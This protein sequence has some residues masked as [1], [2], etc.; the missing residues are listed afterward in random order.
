MFLNLRLSLIIRCPLRIYFLCLFLFKSDHKLSLGLLLRETFLIPN[1]G[2]S[3]F[4]TFI[5]IRSIT[6]HLK[7]GSSVRSVMFLFDGEVEFVKSLIHRGSFLQKAGVPSVSQI[8][9]GVIPKGILELINSHVELT[10][11]KLIVLCLEFEFRGPCWV[12]AVIS[13]CPQTM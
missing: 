6:I 9:D 1:F 5:K 2:L 3:L 13:T 12:V 4:F 7:E 10:R 11:F 8:C